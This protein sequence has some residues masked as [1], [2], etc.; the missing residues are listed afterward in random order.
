MTRKLTLIS[1]LL[2]AVMMTISV[3]SAQDDTTTDEEATSNYTAFMVICADRAII[4]LAGTL[5][6]GVDMYFQV[7]NGAG[8]TGDALSSLRRVAVD[9]EFTFS[10]SVTYPEGTTIAAGGFGSVYV[11]IASETDPDD[12]EFSEFVDDIQDGCAEPQNPTGVSSG[13]DGS[14]PGGDFPVEGGTVTNVLTPFGTFL[15][16]GYVPPEKPANLLGPRDDFELPRQST[17]GLIFAECD[18]FPVAEPGIIYDTDNIIIFWSW[19]AETEELAN[20]HANNANYSVTYYNTLPLPGVIRTSPELIDG[21][22]WTFYYTNLG[23]LR[24]G[25]YFLQYILTWDR[26]ISDGFAE[27]GPGTDTPIIRSQCSFDI[28]PNPEGREVNHNTWPYQP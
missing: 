25:Q 6:A 24:P 26:A 9:G 5:D 28:L 22:Y 10:E 2:V 13:T 14:A 12:V 4:N 15:N 16:A 23:N 20:E 18:D 27:Y 8:G 21:L 7:F 11:A 1:L 3:T 17:P 19:F